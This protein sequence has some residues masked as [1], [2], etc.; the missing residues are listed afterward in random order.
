MA[1]AKTVA[2]KRRRRYEYDHEYGLS[3]GGKASKPGPRA[4]SRGGRSS[5]RAKAT[6]VKKAMK[7]R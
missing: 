3:H 5:G 1:K 7:K 4:V 2:R 6:T